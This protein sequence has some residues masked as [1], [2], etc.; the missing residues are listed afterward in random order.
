MGRPAGRP[1][2]PASGGQASTWQLGGPPGTRKASR[3]L[4]SGDPDVSSTSFGPDI[5]RG[6]HGTVTSVGQVARSPLPP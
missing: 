5:R 6:T 1:P 4:L 2:H 3:D